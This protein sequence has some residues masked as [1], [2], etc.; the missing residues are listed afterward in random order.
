MIKQML[1]KV[2]EVTLRHDASRF[3]QT[4]FQFGN[5]S[6]RK[7]ILEELCSKLFEIAKTP[8]GHFAVLRAITY[9]KDK[10]EQK[11][12]ASSM[13]GH[14]VA[15]GTNVIGAR[16]VELIMHTY[17]QKVTLDLKAEFYGKK[18][19]VLLPENPK[20]L[21]ALIEGMPDKETSILDHM[22]DLVQKFLDK[23]LLE[24]AYV[25]TFLWEYIKEIV[26]KPNYLDDLLNGLADN[27]NKLLSTKAGS[28]TFCMIA[29]HVGAKERKKIMKLLKGKVL[30][31]LLHDAGH[32]GIMR[33]ID[34]TDDTVTVQ[35]SL[36]EEIRSVEPVIKYK[37]S[38]ELM[39]TPF[40]PLISVAKD[41]HGKKM[42]LRLL[43]PS[44]RHLEPDEEELFPQ[45][46][47]TSKKA[48]AVRRK[49]NLTFI[50]TPLIQ[51]CGKYV[52]DLIR[53]PSGAKVL[54]ELVACFYPEN[55]LENIAKVIA[56]AEL[57]NIELVNE[58]VDNDD[59]ED[60]QDDEE[61]DNE[62][63][64][65]EDEDLNDEGYEN[66]E[67][68]GENEDDEFDENGDDEFDD[69]A[70]A[71]EA[72]EPEENSK[73][74]AKVEEK[75]LLPIQEDPIAH[76]LLKKILTIQA[77]AERAHSKNPSKDKKSDKKNETSKKGDKDTIELDYSNW[78]STT[79]IFN[80]A[81]L[82]LDLLNDNNSIE[83][84]FQ[85]NRPCFALVEL[86]NVPSAR[87][88]ALQLL[89]PFQEKIS[90]L[91]S[92]HVGAKILLENMK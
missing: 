30:E 5:V 85:S 11:K 87:E 1:G 91:A 32:L 46:I 63:Q 37:A 67:N 88:K 65:N 27:A 13:S 19:T 17:A 9:C 89:K 12:I 44:R 34:V 7:E 40:P 31:S 70:E 18:F 49:E 68:D 56:G 22:R 26:G 58:E 64:D 62:E 75:P 51:V 41:W 20:N 24:F 48:P 33:L 23:G 8:Y 92:S 16:T 3:V 73:K 45:E 71:E 77:T 66:E 90:A 74:K 60:E 59:D 55:V 28:K 78:D 47:L 52:N 69:D 36:L 14:F 35:K 81:S 29:T 53:C 54:E 38:G 15:L 57:D 79:N 25:H 80:F 42:L 84:W 83:N 50:K 4:I 86:L 43:A 72:E 2:V 61:Q 21:R 39:G 82:L 10:A 76:S 6:Q